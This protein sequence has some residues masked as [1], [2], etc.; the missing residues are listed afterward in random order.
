MET[1]SIGATVVKRPGS[2]LGLLGWTSVGVSAL[3]AFPL[4]AVLANVLQGGGGSFAHLAAPCCRRS[5]AARRCCC[6]A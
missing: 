6:S 2:P 5:A 1:A 3:L 4:L